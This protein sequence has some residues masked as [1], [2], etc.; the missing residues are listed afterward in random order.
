LNARDSNTS[1]RPVVKAL[2]RHLHDA[3]ALRRNPLVGHFFENG[4]PAAGDRSTE[5]R[6]L[7]SVQEVVRQAAAFCRDADLAAGKDERARCQHAIVTESL[8]GRS[9][10]AIAAR[11]G[12]SVQYCYRQRAEVGERIVRYIRQHYDPPA[13]DALPEADEFQLLMDRALSRAV[14]DDA[15]AAIR[16]CEDVVGRAPSPE[17]QIEAL[18]AVTNVAL[19]FGDVVRAK[20]SYA[21]AVSLAAANL[22][23]ERAERH[24]AEACIDLAGSKLAF[25]YR[26][27]AGEALRLSRRAAAR[28]AFVEA[29]AL[30]HVRELYVESLYQL[31]AG[32]CNLGRL[33][34]GYERFVEAEAAVAELRAASARLRA[35]IT[36]G[37]WQLRNHFLMNSRCW[38]PAWQRERA[39]R[40]AFEHAY[41]AGLHAEAI[42]ALVALAEHYA[43]ARNGE[44]ALRA[45][46]LA[47]MLAGQ[48]G[49]ER[50][51]YA[52]RIRVAMALISSPHWEYAA[53]LAPTPD[54]T[55]ACDA[56]HQ[57]L[58]LQF[59][60]ELAL[61]R[62]DFQAAWRLAQNRSGEL[63]FLTVG[64]QI[65]AAAAANELERP[66]DARELIEAAIADAER[67]GAAP[68]LH[69]AYTTAAR[70]TGA[71]RFKRR[72]RELR[73]LL[74]A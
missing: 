33:E 13:L 67:L 43:N 66:S 32:F 35:R 16:A 2:F 65:I 46:R 15:Q 73:R 22:D 69:Y 38:R 26:G 48:Q 34:E 52:T 64:K 31:G 5:Q 29:G 21:A 20:A 68:T 25:F 4:G 72:A 40:A 1:L 74:M 58:A 44:G 14:G 36:I 37:A 19:H 47:V 30:P 28:L 10:G 54:E 56:H 62:H 6:F 63:P 27:D 17:R 45:G 50:V 55:L 71:V 51:H 24:V 42:D 41:A 70:V 7:E 8:E 53:A 49:S 61:R 60:L 23:G 39:F 57:A 9:I 12:I 11:L 59:P 3:R 18:R